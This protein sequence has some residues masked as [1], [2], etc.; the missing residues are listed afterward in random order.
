MHLSR[1]VFKLSK[2]FEYY[3]K[4]QP[5]PVT[6]KSLIDFAVDGDI[7]DSYKFLRVEL[8]VRWS[9]MRKEMNYIPARLLE[10]PSLK[11]V[12]SL[13]D[14][15]FS[16]ILAFKNVEPT[17][18][19]LRNFTETLVG[20]QRRHADVVPTFARAYME[21]EQTGPVDLI[22]KNHLQYFYDRIFMNRIG[23]RTLIYQHTFLF[24]NEFPQRPQQVGII[25]PHCDVLS[26]VQD[27][28]ATAKNLFERALYR[29]PDI[30]ISSYNARSNETGPV[31]VV[32]I[33]A[34]IYHIVFELLKNSLRATV[35]RCGLDT[36]TY[37][38]VQ[39]R[40]VKGHEDLTIEIADRGGGVPRS[41]LSQLFHYTYT[42]APKP[43]LDPSGDAKG[44]PI[45]GL[46]YGLPIARLYAKYFQGS[47]A[48]ASVEGLG[49]WAY[50]SI[51]AE[52]ENA[53]EL[54]PVSSKLRYSYTTK[55]GSDWTS[56]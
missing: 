47:L 37:P 46:G 8:L 28:Y 17:A 18:T 3:A 20:I 30:E 15:S 56:N 11:H 22:E 4:F 2:H 45:A 43:Q 39:V 16:E 50:I 1:T 27:A 10:M 49:T 40:I 14:Q 44:T 21:M 38:P 25:D 26:V 51:K 12:N 31:T 42:T 41:K 13:Y 34:H 52:P 36:K 6:L 24:G 55:K 29:I 19:T 33:P 7:K 35:E 23:I 5:T 48:L 54:L 53:S 32:Y 9:H